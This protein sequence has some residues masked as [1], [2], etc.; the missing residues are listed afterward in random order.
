MGT[1][2]GATDFRIASG[3]SPVSRFLLTLVPDGV[4]IL[5]YPQLRGQSTCIPI[6]LQTEFQGLSHKD[7]LD[8]QATYCSDGGFRD[9]DAPHQEVT[10]PSCALL[11]SSEFC[12]ISF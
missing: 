2:S 6:P 8:S 11:S 4:G 9:A 3:A 10:L 7:I 1:V 12:G 5:R